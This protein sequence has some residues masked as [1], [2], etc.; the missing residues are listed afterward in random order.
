S[1]GPQASVSYRLRSRSS[2]PRCA[3]RSGTRRRQA[4]SKAP[5][6]PPALE[7]RA[8][9]HATARRIRTLENSAFSFW[10]PPDIAFAA[11]TWRR[12]PSAPS[13]DRY[14]DVNG[15]DKSGTAHH[16]HVVKSVEGQ[17]GALPLLADLFTDLWEHT[18]AMPGCCARAESGHAATP[19]SV[20]KNFRRSM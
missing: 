7:S 17:P 19:P 10:S 18:N 16:Q 4:S 2:R 15:P 5:A 14:K 3:G 1:G 13:R 20:A 6:R 12:G 9:S 8:R 11:V